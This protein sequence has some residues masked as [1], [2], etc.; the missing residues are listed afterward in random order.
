MFNEN[1]SQV[2]DSSFLLF[3]FKIDL[4]AYLVFYYF[5]VW[6][7]RTIGF[8][9]CLKPY[10]ME[11]K[12]EIMFM[13]FGKAKLHERKWKVFNWMRILLERDYKREWE[14]YQLAAGHNSIRILYFWLKVCISLL[15]CHFVWGI[16]LHILY[17]H[18]YSF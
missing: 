12:I 13:G 18:V 11:H 9:L 16:Y 8:A 7:I 10:S 15:L 5:S 3:V 14:D 6:F 4:I 17:I 1:K 2:F